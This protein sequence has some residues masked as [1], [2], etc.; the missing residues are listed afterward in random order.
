MKKNIENIYIQNINYS[1]LYIIKGKSGDILIDTGFIVRKKRLKKWLD[2]Y[3]IKLIILTHAHIDHIWNAAY[4]KKLYNCQIALGINDL[5]NIDNSKIN[6]VPSKKRH[7]LWTKIMNYGM[8]K[9]IPNL[10]DIDILLKNNQIIRRCGIELKIIDL[11]GHTNGSIGIIY[12]NYLFAGDALVNRFKK[13]Q[14]EYQNQNHQGA[15]KTYNKILSISPSIIF[16]GHDKYITL[17]QLE[18][19][20]YKINSTTSR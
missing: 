10:F 19:N 1:N 5:Y 20:K 11:P 12:K 6:S 8:K 15:L 14:I 3:N 13:I 4:I 18:N 7:Y 16:I 17:K 2:K 9:I